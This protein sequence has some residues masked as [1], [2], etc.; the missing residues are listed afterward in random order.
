MPKI[1]LIVYWNVGIYNELHFKVKKLLQSNRQ[2]HILVLPQ[3]L[4]YSLFYGNAYL[5]TQLGLGPIDSPIDVIICTPCGL[6]TLPMYLVHVH[7]SRDKRYLMLLAM[8]SYSL[9]IRKSSYN[10][11]S[12]TPKVIFMRRKTIEFDKLHI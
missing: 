6:K 7:I 8:A 12:L 10:F 9:F 3:L 1:Q 5:V 11:R 2:T 4:F